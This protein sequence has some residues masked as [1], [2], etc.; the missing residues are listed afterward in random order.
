MDYEEIRLDKQLCFPIYACAKEITRRYR[1]YLDKI[2]LTYTQYITMMV[3][4]ERRNICVKDLG[5]IL[6]LDSGTLTPLLKKLEQKGLIERKRSDEDERYL[7]ICVTDKGLALR[8]EACRIQE[9]MCKSVNISEDEARTLKGILGKIME[10][11]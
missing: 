2:D 3:L 5:S 6:M 8:S 11:E 9:N 7:D 1:P 4:W 10:N